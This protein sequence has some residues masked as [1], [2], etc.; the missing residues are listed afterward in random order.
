MAKVVT[1]RNWR[2]TS[3]VIPRSPSIR[4]NTRRRTRVAGISVPPQTKERPLF[5]PVPPKLTFIT[6]TDSKSASSCRPKSKKKPASQ[7]YSTAPAHSTDNVRTYYVENAGT[8]LYHKS[9]ITSTFAAG[10]NQVS[11][12]LT[13]KANDPRLRSDL[14]TKPSGTRHP[15][16]AAMLDD[17]PSH[18]SPTVQMLD[19]SFIHTI[20]VLE[21]FTWIDEMYEE[22]IDHS[23][24]LSPFSSNTSLSSDVHLRSD[25]D[26]STDITGASGGTTPCTDDDGP[27]L[28]P[29]WDLMKVSKYLTGK[30]GLQ[31]FN[32]SA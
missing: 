12:P 15:S 7:C 25:W 14:S 30:N 28:V 23:D 27:C 16:M 3:S 5:L 21:E 10:T 11:K 32:E 19:T 29:S 8:N 2:E 6:E 9:E 1:A 4:T 20:D 22:E 18:T 31:I 24:M 13:P 17:K 26:S